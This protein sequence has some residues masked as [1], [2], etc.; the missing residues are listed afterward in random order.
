ME[1]LQMKY[2]AIGVLVGIVIG[3]LLMFMLEGDTLWAVTGASVVAAIGVVT[4]IALAKRRSRLS[5][6]HTA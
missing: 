5:Q 3:S 2:T 1:K 6:A 4:D